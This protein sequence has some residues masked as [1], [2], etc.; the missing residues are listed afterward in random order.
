MEKDRRRGGLSKNGV[1]LVPYF[2]KISRRL[3]A[4]DQTLISKDYLLVMRHGLVLVA[5]SSIAKTHFCILLM[6]MVPLLS[7]LVILHNH[8]KRLWC[9]VF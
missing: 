8:R 6:V 4:L 5:M 9:F 3:T 7:G 1:V 2:K